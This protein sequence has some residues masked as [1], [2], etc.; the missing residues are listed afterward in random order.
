MSSESSSPSGYDYKAMGFGNA[1]TNG[2]YFYCGTVNGLPAYD[3]SRGS[4][5]WC[6]PGVG[7]YLSDG[8][9]CHPFGMSHYFHAN[10][11]EDPPAWTVVPP[12][13]GAVG[14]V[15]RGA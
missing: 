10:A 5:L 4:M 12:Q 6:V 15:T 9:G 2:Y 13:M 8:S 3:N 14:T 11:P 7:W 1:P